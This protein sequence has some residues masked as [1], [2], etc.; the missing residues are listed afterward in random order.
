VEVA[1]LPKPTAP[2]KGKALIFIKLKVIFA[3]TAT[4]GEA[5]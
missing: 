3:D 5:E 1:T 2:V 4:E